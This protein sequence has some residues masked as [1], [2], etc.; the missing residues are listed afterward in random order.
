MFLTSRAEWCSF[1]AGLGF[2]RQV[3][4]LSLYIARMSKK[5]IHH[6]ITTSAAAD[7]SP[8]LPL[9]TLVVRHEFFTRPC[10]VSWRS[11]TRAQSTCSSSSSRDVKIDGN[12]FT[13][14]KTWRDFESNII[15][16][17]VRWEGTRVMSCNETLMSDDAARR[18][19]STNQSSSIS[20]ITVCFSTAFASAI[21]ELEKFFVDLVNKKWKK[22]KFFFGRQYFNFEH[23]RFNI[24]V[25]LGKC[26]S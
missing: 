23:S 24:S 20:W 14:T 7:M 1:K 18:N 5:H 4:K 22:S 16:S 21:C 13:F 3:I 25:S 15:R 26:Y 9:S 6:A 17:N 19:T 8:T 2:V 11:L 10:C 12:I